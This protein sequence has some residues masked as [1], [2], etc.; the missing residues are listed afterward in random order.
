MRRAAPVC[1]HH[2][3]APDL[4]RSHRSAEFAETVPIRDAAYGWGGQADI[5]DH[6]RARG[7]PVVR[8]VG[9]VAQR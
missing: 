4:R 8:R 1:E 2:T 7:L 5:V 9:Q 6:A 3:D